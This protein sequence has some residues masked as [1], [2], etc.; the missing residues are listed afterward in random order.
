MVTVLGGS[1]WQGCHEAC[2]GLWPNHGLLDQC[3]I[4][5]SSAYR[6]HMQSR[7]SHVE[8]I[9]QT[10]LNVALR[11]LLR[12]GENRL[13]RKDLQQQLND[14]KTLLVMMQ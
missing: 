5:V 8:P 2:A 13:S 7:F 9:S 10:H 4:E 3:N 14:C 1:S 11:R 12:R 6:L